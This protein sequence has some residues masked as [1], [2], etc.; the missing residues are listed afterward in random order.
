MVEDETRVVDAAASTASFEEPD[1]TGLTQDQL[2]DLFVNDL[3]EEKGQV[4]FRDR[5]TANS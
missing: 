3:V 5:K 4:I 2:I 1:L